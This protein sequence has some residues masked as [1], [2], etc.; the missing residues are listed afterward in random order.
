MIAKT[1]TRPGRRRTVLACGLAGALALV[2]AL[3]GDPATA[4]RVRSDPNAVG[5]LRAAADA[6][7][8]VPYEGRRFLTTWNRSRSSTSRITVSH[9]PGDGI[10]YRSGTGAV[11]GHQ[12][13]SG[14]DATDPTGFTPV[15]L[16]LL[17]RNYSVVRGADSAVCDRPARVIEAR[18]ADGSPAGRFWIDAET[19]LM[20]HRELI[21]ATGRRVVAA[22]FSEI[23]YTVPAKQPAT[24]AIGAA[25]R[26]GAERFPA[27]GGQGAAVWSDRLDRADLAA[28]RDRGWPVPKDLPGRLTLHDA[29][30]DGNGGAVHLSYSDGLAAVSV[31]VQR[32]TIDER[33]L[34]G[35]QKTVKRGRTIF[36]RES[37]RR[38]AVSAG[39]GFV[40][41]VLTDAPL[42]TADAVAASLPRDTTS[43]WTRVSR[44]AH[45]L[46]AVANPFD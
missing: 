30:R 46:T 35:W 16:D 40:Y 41:T 39:D 22:G 23:R 4:R 21:D 1:V 33:T 19:G 38:W 29:R 34:S 18:R 43:F 15:T 37:L 20:L 13:D 42:S 25:P 10:R 45:R 17:T 8:R 44:G 9:T 31:F 32:G 5:L 6:A 28:L 26:G 36:H 7:R 3:A 24:Y 27:S 11:D 14:P 2:A 12:P